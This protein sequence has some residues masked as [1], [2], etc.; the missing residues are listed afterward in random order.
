VED[1]TF[2][3]GTLGLFLTAGTSRAQR[4]DNVVADVQ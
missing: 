2:A 4:A 3:D 1:S